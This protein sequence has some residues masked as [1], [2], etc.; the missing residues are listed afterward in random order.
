MNGILFKNT[1]HLLSGTCIFSQW[2][3][4]LKSHLKFYWGRA[5]KKDITQFLKDKN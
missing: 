1:F 4:R 3:W 2:A 5:Y